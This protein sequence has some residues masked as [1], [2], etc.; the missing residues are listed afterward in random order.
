MRPTPVVTP[1]LVRLAFC[2]SAVLMALH[3]W[4]MLTS[5]QGIELPKSVST[6][7]LATQDY[8]LHSWLSIAVMASLGLSCLML[9][10]HGRRLAWTVCGLF[11]LFLSVDDFAMLHESVGAWVWP[12][13]EDVSI[14]GWVV[15][16]G[17]VFAACGLLVYR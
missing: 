17:P 5:S 15:V 11:F 2:A 12:Y 3:C 8:G 4:L 7:L 16:M 1:R 10:V 13:F 9:A 6:L 14:C